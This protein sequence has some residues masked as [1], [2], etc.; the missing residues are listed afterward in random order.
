VPVQPGQ[1]RFIRASLRRYRRL[2]L[3]RFA[4]QL[5]SFVPCRVSW[6]SIRGAGSVHSISLLGWPDSFG[7]HR[8][9]GNITSRSS[10]QRYAPQR[11][12]HALRALLHKPLFRYAQRLNSSV[13]CWN[14]QEQS[15]GVWVSHSGIMSSLSCAVVTDLQGAFVRQVLSIGTAFW[16]IL[17]ACNGQCRSSLGSFVLS[18]PISGDI[19]VLH[20]YAL[21]GSCY[22]FVPCRFPW[23]SIRGGRQCAFY[24][25]I[26]L[27]RFFWGPPSVG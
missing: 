11:F 14:L 25:Y 4:W 22:S 24:R 16:C 2:A 18:M 6:L 12:V 26:W 5:L 1:L 3:I 27:A 17:Q 13:M 8:V 23:W 7:A 9:S 20:S 19:G 21:R 10:R 15:R